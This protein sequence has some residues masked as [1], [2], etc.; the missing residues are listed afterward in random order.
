MDSC[1][2]AAVARRDFDPAFLHLQYG[3]RTEARELRAFHEIADHY[4]VR[5]R[6]VGSLEW[7]A[8]IGG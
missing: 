4:R 2:T 7:I 1:V 6:L 8:R 5:D 3:Q